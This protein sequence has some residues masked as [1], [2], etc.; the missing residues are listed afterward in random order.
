MDRA[1]PGRILQVR[2]EEVVEDIEAATRRILEFLDLPFEVDCL[3]FHLS[4]DPVATASSEQVRRPLNRKGIGSAEP[5][6]RWLG[7]LIEELGPLAEA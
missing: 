2:Y 6:R 7:P 5:Y 1:A 4:T 3:D